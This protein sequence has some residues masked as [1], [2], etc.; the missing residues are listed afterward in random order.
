MSQDISTKR[1]SWI[2]LG[3]MGRGMARNISQKVGLTTPL[4]VYN[5]T[6]QRSHDFAASLS[7]PSRVKVVESVEEAVSS[8]DIIFTSLGD[9][10]SVR[11]VYDAALK[12]PSGIRDKLFV[13]TSTVLPE[14][15]NELAQ[16]TAEAGAGFVACPM[17]GTPVVADSGNL[18]AVPAGPVALVSK[19]TPFLDGVVSRATINL[20]GEEPSKASLLK[21]TGNTFISSMVETLAEG[22]VLAEKSG[23]DPELLQK[24]IGYMF[25]GPYVAYSKRM[26][27][28]DYYKREEPL[29]SV[30]FARK[31]AAHAIKLADAVGVDLKIVK[32]LDGHLAK[33]KEE[34]GGK[35]D[36]SAVYGA[37]RKESGLPYRN[38]E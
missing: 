34:V 6:T 1:V 9:D 8:G 26:L 31:D 10:A 32:A 23:L 4:T 25:P 21:I 27:S 20:G 7:D 13:E 37:M 33:V 5:R 11:G 14:T 29:F 38:G 2:G 16:K 18:V 12:F 15:T 30:D 28:G 3:N 35:G 24:A 17:F 22:H 19:V 36:I